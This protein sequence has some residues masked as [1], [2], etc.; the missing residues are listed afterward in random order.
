MLYPLI[1]VCCIVYTVHPPHAYT[2]PS[3]V[4]GLSIRSAAI[5]PSPYPFSHICAAI[6]GSVQLPKYNMFFKVF[7][8]FYR[9]QGAGPSS[10]PSPAP[11]SPSS[12]PPPPSA[13]GI[14]FFPCL[15]SFQCCGSMTFWCGS[16]SADPCLRLMDPDPDSDPDPGSGSCYFHHWPSKCQQK[17]NFLKQ[18]IL[19]ITF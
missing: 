2:K 5:L 17:T 4:T 14:T 13:S 1:S 16:G 18:W 3:L 15:S 19:L 10:S 6:K 9:S 12:S 11:P 8:P 7:F